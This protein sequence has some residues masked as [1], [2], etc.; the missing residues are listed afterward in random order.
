[1]EPLDIFIERLRKTPSPMPQVIGGKIVEGVGNR[2]WT[3][4]QLTAEAFAQDVLDSGRISWD[5]AL[6]LVRKRL[7]SLK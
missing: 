2:P 3:A 5:A 7:E 4:E 6:E 1:M